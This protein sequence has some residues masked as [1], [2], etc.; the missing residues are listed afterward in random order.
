MQE[1]C[2]RYGVPYT[3][4]LG[5]AE[6]ESSFDFEAY[7]GYAYGLMQI[8]PINYE[9]LREIGI[10]P[11]TKQGN[12]EAGVYMLGQLLK[13]YDVD[14]ALM[15]YNCGETYAEELWDAGKLCSD[16]SMAVQAAA[17]RWAD[18]LR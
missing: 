16:Y 10:D 7:S 9:W 1:C 6:T 2:E 3:L 5:V 11:E 17:M 15:A 12:I 8:S 14:R 18:T 4:A 13:S